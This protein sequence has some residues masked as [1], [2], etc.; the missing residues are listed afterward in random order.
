MSQPL[1]LQLAEFAITT[2]TIDAPAAVIN[3]ASNALVDTIGCA[4]GGVVEPVSQITRKMVTELGSPPALGVWGTGMRASLLDAAFLN[5]VASHAL[6]FDDNLPSQRGHPSTTVFPAALAAAAHTSASGRD[7]L[8]AY[9]VGLEVSGKLGRA[10]GP[11]HYVRGYHATATIGIFGATTAAARILRLTENQLAQAWGLAASQ[12]SGLLANFGTMAKPF[13]AGHAARCALASALLVR[14]GVTASDHIFDGDRS[15][16]A[17]YRGDDAGGLAPQLQRL[18]Q[19]WDILDPG[20]FVKRWAC[21]L[22]SHRPLAGVMDLLQKHAVRAEEITAIDIG[23]PPGTDAGL[24]DDLPANGLAGKFSIEYAAAVAILDGDITLHSFSDAAF[25]R[26]GVHQLMSRVRRY[27]MPQEPAGSASIGH[28]Y[29]AITT[30]RGRFETRVD[31]LPGSP[32]NPLSREELDAKFIGCAEPVLGAEQAAQALEL[33]RALHQQP[34]CTALLQA[35]TS[36]RD[37]T[38]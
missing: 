38:S 26:Q 1:T 6:D 20:V 10:V 37:S 4:L 35:L 28:N 13:H 25:G 18:G 31:T 30:P 14:A 17:T 9:A 5:G 34:D 22:C 32:S 29:V 16:I 21:C 24:V 23:F 12:M 15:M 7:I 19:P 33:T 2:R 3:A 36:R 8:A 27:R 11:G